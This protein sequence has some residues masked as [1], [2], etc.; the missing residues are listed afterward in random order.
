VKLSLFD[1]S[2]PSS[3]AETSFVE[4]SGGGRG[5]G[6]AWSMAEHDHHAFSSFADRGVLAIPVSRWTWSDASGT[7]SGWNGLVVYAVDLGGVDSVAGFREIGR[8]EH[9]STV[10]R[11]LR[12]GDRL[13]SITDSELK[14]VELDDP[15]TVV[16]VLPLT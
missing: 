6:Y 3:P 16:A 11:S 2:V 10:L 12:I 15:S 4:I 8:I 7:S 5:T 1:V 14:V 9:G 13:H